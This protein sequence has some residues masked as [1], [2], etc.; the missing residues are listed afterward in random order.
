[1]YVCIPLAGDEIGDLGIGKRGRTFDRALRALEGEHDAGFLAG[2]ARPVEVGG[3]GRTGQ[4]LEGDGP[5]QR[6]GLGVE[7]GR[8]L[9][10]GG[11]VVRWNFV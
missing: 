8:C 3:N 5:R 2:L 4:I 6:L 10:G 7:R 11:A 1:V 9:A